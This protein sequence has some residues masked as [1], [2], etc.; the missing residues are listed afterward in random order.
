LR[1]IY[2]DGENRIRG[3]SFLKR[4]SG[5]TQDNMEKSGGGSR[6]GKGTR[7]RPLKDP[8]Y[9][10]RRRSN[11]EKGTLREENNRDRQLK[12]VVKERKKKENR[13]RK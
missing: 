4:R 8:A 1:H 6:E 2:A 5:E 7:R 10:T 11:V 12:A 13:K 3:R 9:P